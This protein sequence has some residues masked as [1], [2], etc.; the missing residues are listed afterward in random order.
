[1]FSLMSLRSKR[2]T[3]GPASRYDS[4]AVRLA[5]PEDEP[6]I[7]RLA[8][9]DGKSVPKGRLLVA[10]ADSEVI[11]ALPVAGG[12]AVA[13]PFRWTSDVVALMEMRAEQ[14]AGAEVAPQPAPSGAVAK[15]R[16]QL[17]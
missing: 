12:S 16:A 11:A 10:E 7:R 15:L 13:D 2:S 1:M 4:V 9:L 6:A 5:R 14:L 17:T 3:S 8:S